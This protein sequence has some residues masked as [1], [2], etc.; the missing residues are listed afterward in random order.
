MGDALVAVDAG[1]LAAHQERLMR[2]G[3]A[4]ALPGEVH[5]AEIVAVAAFQRIVRL[6]ADPFAL[7]QLSDEEWKEMREM[8]KTK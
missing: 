8:T 2:A 7:G 3:R 4:R 1:L 6:Q 5:V